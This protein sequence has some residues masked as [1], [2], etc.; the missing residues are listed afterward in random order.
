MG[1][2]IDRCL[3]RQEGNYD[4]VLHVCRHIYE[5]EIKTFN[6]M[7]IDGWRNVISNKDDFENYQLFFPMYQTFRLCFEDRVKEYMK[8]TIGST[9]SG[10]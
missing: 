2:D 3:K 6:H 8:K 9:L 7:W 1:R 4:L 5:L 10:S